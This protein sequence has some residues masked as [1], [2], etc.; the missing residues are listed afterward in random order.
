MHKDRLGP[1]AQHLLASYDDTGSYSRQ[2]SDEHGSPPSLMAKVHHMRSV[3]QARFVN[4]SNYELGSRYLDYGRVEFADLETGDRYLLKS[5]R[6]VAIETA[7]ARQQASLFPIT[8]LI[9]PSD[10]KVVVYQFQRH[11]LNLSLAP[12]GT[13]GR[14]EKV[15]VADAPVLIGTWAYQP[16]DDDTAE[17]TKPF[18]QDA[19]DTF[20]DLG[21]LGHDEEAGGRE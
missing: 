3:I 17:Q 9:R 1:V 5:S 4:D 8:N 2:F 10:I 19:R 14:S 20:G 11:G 12:A 7:T 15:Y 6:A 13:R 21:D 16:A 18:D